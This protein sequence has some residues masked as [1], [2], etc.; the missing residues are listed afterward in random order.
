VYKI[1]FAPLANN[2]KV[3]LPEAS[4]AR[5]WVAA[6]FVLAVCYLTLRQYFASKESIFFYHLGLAVAGLGG[7]VGGV[8]G[9]FLPLVVDRVILGS[10][11]GMALLLLDDGSIISFTPSFVFTVT[12]G[13][14]LVTVAFATTYSETWVLMINSSLVGAL[15]AIQGADNYLNS[16]VWA[17]IEAVVTESWP[18]T[19]PPDQLLFPMVLLWLALAALGVFTQC[20]SF[21]LTACEGIVRRTGSYEALAGGTLTGDHGRGAVSGVGE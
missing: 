21:K 17:A 7:L 4:A 8:F 20:L 2:G 15:F 12:I 14:C 1:R 6:V 13:L 16:G 11:V 18:L 3:R 9:V 5:F 10:M 19:T